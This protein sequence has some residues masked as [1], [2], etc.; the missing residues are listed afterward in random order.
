MSEQSE[1][2]PFVDYKQDPKEVNENMLVKLHEESEKE[3]LG[4][5]KIK[6]H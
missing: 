3:Q 1:L 4:Q 6:V 5:I 2:T